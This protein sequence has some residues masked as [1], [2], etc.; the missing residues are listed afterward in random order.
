[1]DYKQTLNLPQTDFPIRANLAKVEVEMQDAWQSGNIYHEI[2]KK[3]QGRPLYILR[4]GPPYPNGDIHL[5]HALNKILKDIIVKYKSM[6]GFSSPYVPGWDC[7]GLPI[8]TQLLKEIRESGNQ[9]IRDRIE[10]RNK[11]KEYALKY[12][13]LQRE[14]FKKLGVFGE[15]DKPY[16]TIDHS[17]EAK[18]IELFGILAEN[19]Y[20]YRGLKP[21]HWCPTDMTALAEAELEYEDDRSPS[22]YV[23]FEIQNQKSEILNKFK[24]QNPK[25]KTLLDLP[26]H[27]IIWTTTP[28]TLPSNVAVAAHPD[29]E[30]VF[31]DVGNEV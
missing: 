12:V 16:L 17:Y 8:E 22:I 13:D 19:G 1:M 4:D 25:F 18:I 30:Y 29:Y 7:H 21:I 6:S 11:C 28:W 3:N 27:V 9:D 14:E 31:L 23:K 10:F 15:W 24:A 20:V 2:Q 26:W 5:G